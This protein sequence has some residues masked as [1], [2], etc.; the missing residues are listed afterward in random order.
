METNERKQIRDI[1]TKIQHIILGKG[2]FND[3]NII[4]VIKFIKWF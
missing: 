4:K 2:G 1:F 3:D